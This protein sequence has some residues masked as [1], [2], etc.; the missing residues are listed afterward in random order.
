MAPRFSDI[1]EEARLSARALLDYG[2][3]LEQERVGVLRD[4]AHRDDIAFAE[5]NSEAMA[6]AKVRPVAS[7]S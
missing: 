6:A 2:E 3:H 5:K 4:C 1:V 7:A